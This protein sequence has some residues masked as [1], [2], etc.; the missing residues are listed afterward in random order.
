MTGRPYEQPDAASYT[1][2]CAAVAATQF[3]ARVWRLTGDPRALDQVE[4][5]LF[6]AVPC[7]V[8]APAATPGSTPSPTPWTRS[9]RREPPG[10]TTSTTG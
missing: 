10:P 6:N 9:A 3:S 7:G 5:L 1:E 4:L 8:G 2:S